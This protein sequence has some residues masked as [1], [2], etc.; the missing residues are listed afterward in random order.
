MADYVTADQIRTETGL[1]ESILTDNI[2]SVIIERATYRINSDLEADRDDDEY[3]NFQDSDSSGDSYIPTAYLDIVKKACLYL[4]CSYAFDFNEI[5]IKYTVKPAK[6][7]FLKY[8]QTW[9]DG[10]K[11]KVYKQKY[12]NLINMLIENDEDTGYFTRSTTYQSEEFIVTSTLENDLSY[13][14]LW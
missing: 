12:I 9:K 8:D 4:C 5:D 13:S 1:S 3:V 2:C 10:A 6:D 11:A 7:E 14:N